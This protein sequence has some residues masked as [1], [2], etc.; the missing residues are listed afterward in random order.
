VNGETHPVVPETS[1]SFRTSSGLCLLR[2]YRSLRGRGFKSGERSDDAPS[3][4]NR[5]FSVFRRVRAES[6]ARSRF[7]S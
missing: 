6:R 2:M 5:L 3:E 4:N 1:L 7:A